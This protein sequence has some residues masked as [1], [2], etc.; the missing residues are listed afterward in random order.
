MAGTT[1]QPLAITRAVVPAGPVG[2]AEGGRFRM[3]GTDLLPTAS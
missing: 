2:G 3:T 1:M